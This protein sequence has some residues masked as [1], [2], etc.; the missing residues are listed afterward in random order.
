MNVH[1]AVIICSQ[2]IESTFGLPRA[3]KE[4]LRLI[5]TKACKTLYT[6]DLGSRAGFRVLGVQLTFK[7]CEMYRRDENTDG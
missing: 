1:D 7:P 3:T 4:I 6:Q 5:D 2:V